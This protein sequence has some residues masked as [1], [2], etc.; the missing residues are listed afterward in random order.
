LNLI[1]DKTTNPTFLLLAYS[2]KP[3][4]NQPLI[5]HNMKTTAQLD[6]MYDEMINL[7]LCSTDEIELVTGINGYKEETLNEIV[8]YKTGYNS[9][10]QYLECTGMDGDLTL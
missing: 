8:Y 1:G 5:K 4:T 2:S 10:E 3:P 7:E 9:L 6:A